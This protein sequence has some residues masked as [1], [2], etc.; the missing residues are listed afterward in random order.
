MGEHS[1][2]GELDPAE[3]MSVRRRSIN[4]RNDSE[5]EKVR[6]VSELSDKEN[7]DQDGSDGLEIKF[8]RLHGH[9]ECSS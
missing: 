6:P 2:D 4:N 1:E 7:Q 3:G 8:I 9:M 5:E